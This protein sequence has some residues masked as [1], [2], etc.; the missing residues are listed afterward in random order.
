MKGTLLL[1]HFDFCMAFHSGAW[2]SPSKVYSTK[3]LGNILVFICLQT[4]QIKV[5]EDPST[6][7]ETLCRKGSV[8]QQLKS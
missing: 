5:L 2:T 7:G 3:R 4:W 6:G 8:N 1:V